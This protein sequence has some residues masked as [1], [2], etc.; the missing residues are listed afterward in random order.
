[1]LGAE[2]GGGAVRPE[3]VQLRFRDQQIGEAEYQGQSLF[4]LGQAAVARRGIAEAL[5]DVEEGML[6]LRPH[7]S[8]LGE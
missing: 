2:P 6:D 5:L 8:A 4:V 7:R 3:S 1:M